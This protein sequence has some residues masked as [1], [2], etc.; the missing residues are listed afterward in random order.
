[1][2][3]VK[4]YKLIILGD[5]LLKQDLRDLALNLG[6]QENIIFAGYVENPYPFFKK[7]SAFIMCS[8]F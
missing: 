3:G 5:G 1:M 4:G 8:D 6:I 7:A 2:P